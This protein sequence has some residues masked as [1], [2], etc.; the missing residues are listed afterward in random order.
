MVL[1]EA[2]GAGVSVVAFAVGGIPDVLSVD[3]GWPVPVG[4]VG[5]LADSISMVLARPVEA[6]R[7]SDIARNIVAARFNVENWMAQL[8]DVYATVL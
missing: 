8:E 5:A 2:M 1:L 7:R 4:D 6:A 3:A